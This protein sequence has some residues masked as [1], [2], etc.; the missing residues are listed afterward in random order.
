MAKKTVEEILLE[1][2]LVTEEDINKVRKESEKKA[3]AQRSF[4]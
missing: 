2:A 1:K 4:L 3:L